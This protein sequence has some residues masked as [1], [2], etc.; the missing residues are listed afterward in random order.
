MLADATMQRN[1]VHDDTQAQ[2]AKTQ[3]PTAAGSSPV[4][5]AHT[6]QL[7]AAGWSPVKGASLLPKRR[8]PI[9]APTVLTQRSQ[10]PKF[11]DAGTTPES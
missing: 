4:I 6:Q 10:I 9:A 7:T 3:Q 11:A 1:T 2:G 8:V 5:N